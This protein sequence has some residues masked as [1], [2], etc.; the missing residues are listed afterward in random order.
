[1]IIDLSFIK[2]RSFE[3]F[4]LTDY[5]S[6]L[7]SLFSHFGAIEPNTLSDLSTGPK[8][9]SNHYTCFH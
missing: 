7:K 2:L 1:M 4:F 8:A 9:I 3:K 5:R 6:H